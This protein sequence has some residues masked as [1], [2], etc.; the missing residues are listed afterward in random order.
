M[1]QNGDTALTAA[2]VHLPTYVEQGHL[3]VVFDRETSMVGPSTLSRRYPEG[4]ISPPNV[5]ET[6][7]MAEPLAATSEEGD[8]KTA[9]LTPP[10]HK[11][12]TKES[13]RL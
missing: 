11:I 10:F 5:P 4:T 12:S 6:D 7:K 1:A 3:S 9:I 13:P 8:G 2:N